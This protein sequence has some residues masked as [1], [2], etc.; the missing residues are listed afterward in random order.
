MVLKMKLEVGMNTCAASKTAV[1]LE[2]NWGLLGEF[3]EKGVKTRL[4][5]HFRAKNSCSRRIYCSKS[6][7]KYSKL[8]VL[9]FNLTK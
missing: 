5:D 3:Q 4:K 2:F 1:R 7:Q 6:Y 8:R 9:K